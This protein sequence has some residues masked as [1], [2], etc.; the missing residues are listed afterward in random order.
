MKREKA[1]AQP[2]RD[3]LK[4]RVLVLDGA[5]GTMIQRHE[6]SEADFRG[7]RF[8]HHPS[9]L[10]GANDILTLTQPQIIEEIHR[11]YFAAGADIVE[12]N[13][14]SST[15]VGMA[16]YGV[17]DAIYKLNVQAARIARAPPTLIQ[18]LK[19][20]VLSLARLAQQTAPRACHRMSTTRP[21]AP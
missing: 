17:D 15:T 16:E 12:T 4:E 21:F 1:S 7:E 5:M 13:T 6:L 3:A 10:Q 9:P 14:F 20:P 18:R 11:E 19:N 2:L 8:K